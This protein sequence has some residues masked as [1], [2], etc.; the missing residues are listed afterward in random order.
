MGQSQNHYAKT[1]AL[2]ESIYTKLKKLQLKSM[3][4]KGKSV[5]ASW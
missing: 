5:L 4:R 2:D 3:A 1:K